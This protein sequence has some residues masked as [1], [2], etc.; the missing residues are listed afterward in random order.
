MVADEMYKKH[1]AK[2]T[3]E[4]YLKWICSYIH[5]HNKRHPAHM[6]DTEVEAYLSHLVLQLDAAA[7]TQSTALNA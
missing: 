2:R 1:Y 7:K 4:T 5:F 3:I 6:H